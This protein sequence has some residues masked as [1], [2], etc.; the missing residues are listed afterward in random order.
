M[1]IFYNLFSTIKNFFKAILSFFFRKN[2][3]KVQ[4]RKLINTN[5][6]ANKTMNANLNDLLVY[7]GESKSVLVFNTS[8]EKSKSYRE[9]K[10]DEFDCDTFMVEYNRNH[11]TEF[12]AIDQNKKFESVIDLYFKNKPDCE[13]VYFTFSGKYILAKITNASIKNGKAN[14]YLID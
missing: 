1:T 7:Q 5:S 9:F 8:L 14:I 12:K 10:I 13:D 2:I 11:E 6:H 4:D 3:L